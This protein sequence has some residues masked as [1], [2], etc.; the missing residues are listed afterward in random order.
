MIVEHVQRRLAGA[1][2]LCA[3][4]VG[5]VPVPAAATS[6]AALIPSFTLVV[7]PLVGG[8]IP[9]DAVAVALNVTVT[10]P[11]G[12]GYVTVYPCGDRPGVSNLNY[13]AGQTVPNFVIAAL[14]ADG[15]VCIDTIATTDVIVDIAG[16][17]PAGSP[18]TLLEQ[19]TRFLDTRDGTGAPKRR[20]Q[21]GET[22][23]VRVAGSPGVPA[24]A[25]A[26]VFNATAVIASGSGF[27]TVFPC[28]RP[29]PETSTLNVTAGSIV[30]NLVTTA[31]GADGTVCIYSSV[32]TDL[33]GDVAAYLPA[34]SSGVTLFEAPKRVVDTRSGIG[35]PAAP[36][37]SLV[38]R[39]VTNLT[40]VPADATAVITNL[41]ATEGVSAGWMSAFPCGPVP[42]VSNVNYSAGQNI[43]NHAYVPIVNGRFC[44][45]SNQQTHAVVDIAGYVSGAAAF[46]PMTPERLYD[47]REEA[48][49][50]C[51]LGLRRPS[52]HADLRLVDLTTGADGPALVKSGPI[53]L[54]VWI[55]PGCG[56][57]AT[58][59]RVVGGQQLRLFDRS[60]SV[61][62]TREFDTVDRLFVTDTG[63]VGFDSGSGTV[64]EALTDDIRF[65]LPTRSLDEW[66][67]SNVSATGSTLV[68][69]HRDSSGALDWLAF[70]AAGGFLGAIAPPQGVTLYSSMF[71]P[72]AL[73]PDGS[74]LLYQ[75]RDCSR[76]SLTT[77]CLDTGYVVATFDGT[78]VDRL[79][80]RVGAPGPDVRWQAA[81][82]ASN[83]TVFLQRSQT[84][85]RTAPPFV[86]AR[87]GMARWELFH[88]PAT[89]FDMP[90]EW[91]RD[92]GYVAVSAAR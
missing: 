77:P 67:L 21:A 82:W 7:S 52:I 5:L 17:V 80:P 79:S 6:G 44:L 55:D 12:P 9:F 24:S 69:H 78:V 75:T 48:K 35:G 8:K 26:V 39:E 58:I 1:I 20:V 70:D 18:L 13:V 34:G 22:L 84:D 2:A 72:G 61:T 63:I 19:P 3:L 16:Y 42:P 54:N 59:N 10:E 49:V 38:Q 51:N 74:Y 60:G 91:W 45:V 73:S 57:V 90:F 76:T 37:A 71:A 27:V 88:E 15:D 4:A 11:V 87:Y 36:L 83:G 65:S 56:Q 62:S 40:G 47:S 46:V 29:I 81:V 14:D 92:P 43:A 33:V 23:P 31:V 66:Y 32:D 50:R 53:T 30:P 85:Y 89:V 41:T 25:A 86:T 68:F 28:G 64:Y